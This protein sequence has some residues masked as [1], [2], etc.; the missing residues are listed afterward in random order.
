MNKQKSVLKYI[1]AG[2]ITR[3]YIITPDGRSIIDIQGGN[4]LYAA[5]GLRL[6]DDQI[7]LLSV[8]SEDYPVEWLEEVGRKGFDLR[9]IQ[10][11]TP[12]FDQRFFIAFP[13][14]YEHDLKNP[15]SHFSRI[16]EAMPKDLLGYNAENNANP[17]NPAQPVIIIK[18]IPFDYLDVTAVHISALDFISQSR[19]PSFFRQGHAS[20]ITLLASDEY[21][22]TTYSEL[23][24]TILKD[25]N[26]FICTEKQIRNL[27]KGKTNDIWEMISDLDTYRC[28]MIIVATNRNQFLFWDHT[29]EKKYE[30]SLY[31]STINDPTG[32]VDSFCGGFISGL[33]KFQDP[34][35]A[36]YRGSIS[37]SFTI[38]GTGPFYCLDAL[39]R[40]VEARLDYVKPQ[41]TLI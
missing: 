8:I 6:W 34:L 9:G 10:S 32:L 21:M 33:R 17:N 29:V 16:N 11:V 13:N 38:E 41:I 26:A 20:T 24:P 31:P 28:E 23:V 4:L 15:I 7:G 2:R 1:V 12:P 5:S 25:I 14:P 36:L 35:E 18:D 3:D 30:I 39:P 19:L 40:L 22:N 37:A 27:Y